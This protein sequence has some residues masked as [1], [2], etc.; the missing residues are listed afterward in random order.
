M[1]LKLIYPVILASILVSSCNHSRSIKNNKGSIASKQL[2]KPV[3]IVAKK[4]SL[5]LKLDT[6]RQLLTYRC[7]HFFSD[8]IQKDSFSITLFGNSIDSA[9]GVF[10]IIAYN[11]KEIYREKFDASDLLGDEYD[12]LNG[13]QQKD[14]IRLRMAH[15]LDTSNFYTPAIDRKE[16]IENSFDEPDSSD[17]R[18]WH[19]VRSDPTAVGFMYSM[20]YESVYVIAYSKRKRKVVLIGYDD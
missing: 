10:K 3:L 12:E 15:L 4:D 18:N 13:E 17:K 14:T 2:H 19:N 1:S 9:I 8:P 11:H 16:K 7:A 20:G 6:T 5:P